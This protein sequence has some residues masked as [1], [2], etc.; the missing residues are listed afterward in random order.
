[1]TVFIL[2]AQIAGFLRPAIFRFTSIIL[3]IG[4]EMKE[5]KVYEGSNLFI[6]SGDGIPRQYQAPRGQISTFSAKSR[7][8]MLLQ[9][10]KI[11]TTK[12]TGKPLFITLTYPRD[13][14]PDFHVWKRNLA[15]FN[16][17]LI[18]K[19]PQIVILW[20]LEFQERGA[21]HFHLLILNTDSKTFLPGLVSMRQIVK[22]S[23]FRIV[24]SKQPEHLDAGTEVDLIQSWR[25]V[26]HYVSKYMAKT[27]QSYPT[28]QEIEFTGRFWGI[29]NRKLLP[30]DETTVELS[31]A[32]FHRLRRIAKAFLEKKLSKKC[33]FHTG[34]SGMFIYLD[35]ETS[36]KL[37]S[38]TFIELS[39]DPT[40]SR[41]RNTPLNPNRFP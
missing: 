27:K 17:V 32:E 8:R 3:R 2:K 15:T 7:K 29:A 25:G 12:I 38:Q 14:S 40:W 36:L 23:W 20:R 41:F 33:Y 31:E 16:K 30:I 6:L 10:N 28:I 26:L 22:T 9:V 19:F 21:P 37:L 39:P 5:A 34:S 1:M 11:N 4:N 18:R 35:R 13:F 24:D